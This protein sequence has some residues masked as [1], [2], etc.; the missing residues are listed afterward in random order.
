MKLSV[1]KTAIT[2]TALISIADIVFLLLIFLLI[3]SNFVTSTGIKIDIPTS[4]NTHSEVQ[5]NIILSI[6]ENL[7]IFVNSVLTSE[8][9]LVIALRQEIESK[10]DA[11]I[12]IEADQNIALQKIIDLIDA[13]KTAGSNRFFI[14]A[15]LKR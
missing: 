1:K 15:Q 3:S 10:P 11:Y 13:S 6:N 5:Q 9:Y 14:A 7:E 2:T 8:E 4:Q 12:R